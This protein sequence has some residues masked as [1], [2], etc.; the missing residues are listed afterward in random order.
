MHWNLRRQGREGREK[1]ADSVSQGLTWK[2]ILLKGETMPNPMEGKL[3]VGGAVAATGLPQQEASHLV[4]AELSHQTRAQAKMWRC[5]HWRVRPAQASK[6]LSEC[7]GDGLNSIKT[8]DHRENI[9]QANVY[10]K[11]EHA[12]GQGTQ[13]DKNKIK[14]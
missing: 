8:K 9:S 3:R 7:P 6:D 1:L 5:W 11:Q 2:P 12:T 13:Y 4:S 10:I 14:D